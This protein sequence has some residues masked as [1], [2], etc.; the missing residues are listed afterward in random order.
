MDVM[1]RTIAVVDDDGAYLRFVERALSTAGFECFRITTFDID[2]TARVIAQSG[3][4]AAIVDIF[5]YDQPSGLACVDAIR[6][7]PGTES[8]P[9]IVASGAHERLAKSSD[10]LRERHCYALSKP[11]GVDQL[12]AT[13][14]QALQPAT[15]PAQTAHRAPVL[16]TAS[17]LVG[18]TDAS[19]QL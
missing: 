13:I 4:A 15:I 3:C 8:L 19:I 11:F 7:H 17:A 9:I 2:E 5:M 12:I 16:E 1:P 14:N 10:F 6:A 18:A